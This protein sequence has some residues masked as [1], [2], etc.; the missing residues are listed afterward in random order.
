MKFSELIEINRNFFGEHIWVAEIIIIIIFAIFLNWLL[1]RYHH[2]IILELKKTKMS[3]DDAFFNAAE[4]PLSVLIWVTAFTFSLNIINEYNNFIILST[5]SSLYQIGVLIIIC[6]FLI[7]FIT[8]YE[9]N[10]IS[11]TET[12][13]EEIDQTTVDAIAKLLRI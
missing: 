12:T 3:W 9:R 8:C 11:F 2:K 5:I 1:K 7:R 10:I 13:S 4:K 6:W